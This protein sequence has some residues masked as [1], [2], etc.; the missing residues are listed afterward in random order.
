VLYDGWGGGGGAARVHFNFCLVLYDGYPPPPPHLG[1]RHSKNVT[2]DS[3]SRCPRPLILRMITP[4][5]SKLHITTFFLH[6]CT[7]FLQHQIAPMKFA[8]MSL[9]FVL[10]FI[11]KDGFLQLSPREA[12]L[13]QSWICMVA[14]TMALSHNFPHLNLPPPP[15]FSFT[16]YVY[17]WL[18]LYN[19]GWHATYLGFI[20]TF[21]DLLSTP[22]IVLWF[23]LSHM[24]LTFLCFV[25]FIKFVQSLCTFQEAKWMISTKNSIITNIYDRNLH[26]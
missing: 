15:L 21:L 18:R 25:P 20:I 23:C 22:S 19:I 8:P 17:M 3:L 14:I 12:R 9:Q 5:G 10:P 7:C 2:Q 11:G 16:I 26:L 24:Y 4:W 1:Q 13:F 6:L